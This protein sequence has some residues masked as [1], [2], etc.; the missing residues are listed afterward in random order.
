M[1]K[2]LLTKLNYFFIEG[3]RYTPSF[4]E[5]ENHKFRIKCIGI[6]SYIINPRP[7]LI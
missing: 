7:K 3:E 4:K 6:N 5:K 1:Y 2:P